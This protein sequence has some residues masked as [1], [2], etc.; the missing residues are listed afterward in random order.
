MEW[1][2]ANLLNHPTILEKAEA[3]IDSQVGQNQTLRLHPPIPLLL[4][5]Y[6]SDDCITG[7]F[8]VPRG[9]ILLVNACAIHRDPEQWS[10]PTSFKP[11]RFESGDGRMN[12]LVIPFGLGRRACPAATLAHKF[13]GLALGSLIQCFE[14]KRIGEAEVDMVETEGLTNAQGKAAG[15]IPLNTKL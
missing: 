10:D 2:F 5:H 8:S 1:A 12:R 7:G 4:P 14:W 6:S 15:S 13:M 9:T 11:E 3:E